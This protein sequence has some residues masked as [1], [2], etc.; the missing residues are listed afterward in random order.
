[1]SGYPRDA[2]REAP[3]RGHQ[4][5][6]AA[7]AV[8][9]AWLT[10]GWAVCLT[11]LRIWA[12][13]PWQV[14]GTLLVPLSYTLV[15]VL[16]SA[17][18]AANPVAVVNA[19]HGPAG[20]QI[21]A[22][23]VNAQVFRVSEVSATAARTLYDSDQIAAIIT[24]P[25][26]TTALLDARRQVRI[27]LQLA[28]IDSDMAD[29]IRRGVPD[30]IITWYQSRSAAR[31]WPVDVTVGQQQMMT[32]DIQLYQ[33]SILPVIIL[34]AT[35]SGILVAGM[36]AA[37]EFERKTVKGLLLAPVP[38]AVIVL[39]KMAAGWAC[40]SLT[41]VLVLALGAAAGWTR[42]ASLAGWAQALIA[43]VLASLFVSGLGV[44][45]GT[46]GRRAQP[47][48][49]FATIAAVELFA[50][51]GGLGVIYFEPQWLQDIAQF[52][53]LTYAIHALQQAVFY[54][55]TAGWGRDAAVLLAS[56]AAAA[57]A[58]TLAMRRGLVR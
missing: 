44:A 26:G 58:G 22:A 51:A 54:Q 20:A 13:R 18:T 45:I 50:L 55:S 43:V 35:V 27:G 40:T 10:A 11:D 6:A 38:P 8:L 14:I 30:A 28:N 47:V 24:I 33:Y 2:R 5:G 29:D 1:M 15:A 37:R 42:P 39:G 32:Q 21:A 53:P 16:G 31:P 46:W 49:I 9:A 3:R 19:D 57:V 23:I 48:S 34:V 4:D 12:R 41:T 7:A 52:D 56:A 17:A 36:M 25:A